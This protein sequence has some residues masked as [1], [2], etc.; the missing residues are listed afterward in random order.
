MNCNGVKARYHYGMKNDSVQWSNVTLSHLEDLQQNVT[1]GRLLKTLEGFSYKLFDVNFLNKDFYKEI[2]HEYHDLAKWLVSD[3]T[4]MHGLALMYF[5]SLKFN[6]P[7]YPELM[8]DY[9]IQFQEWVLFESSYQKLVWSGITRY[10]EEL[11]A[12]VKFESLYNPLE[13]NSEKV[14][15][16]GRSLYWGEYWIS[17]EDKQVEY[18]IMIEDVIFKLRTDAMANPQLLDLQREIVFKKIHNF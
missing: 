18:S 3:A 5:D 17:L 8:E 7:F 9:D 6:E 14:T 12:V 10:N 11:C 2:D 13:M 4:Q 16:K 1:G 15:F